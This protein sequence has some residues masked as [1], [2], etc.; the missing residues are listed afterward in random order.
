MLFFWV[1]LSSSGCWLLWYT[2]MFFFPN[3]RRDISGSNMIWP[4]F[5]TVVTLHVS[6]WQ[7]S[8]FCTW[9]YS[10]WNWLGFRICI[11]QG[12]G[13]ILN[14]NCTYYFKY[15]SLVILI[16]LFFHFENATNLF[17]YH[18]VVDLLYPLCKNI[19]FEHSMQCFFPQNA[20]DFIRTPYFILNSAYDIYQ[21]ILNCHVGH[22]VRPYDCHFWKIVV[23]T[24]GKEAVYHACS[25]L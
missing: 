17:F 25:F 9:C 5:D 23:Y 22:L 7:T 2:N 8:P 12:V 20:L 14:R 19:I 18:S 4:F 10:L 24:L 11:M 13:S 1:I 6:D 3:D 16:T 15:P 21:V